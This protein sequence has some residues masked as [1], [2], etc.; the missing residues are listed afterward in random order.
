MNVAAPCQ[1]GSS[2]QSLAL[3]A[4]VDGLLS[5]TETVVET[6]RLPLAAVDGRVL[7]VDLVSCSAVPPFDNSAMDGYALRVGDLAGDGPWELPV[8]ARLT[9]GTARGGAPVP[10]GRAVRIF[11]GAPMP[12]GF[13]AVV[14]QERCMRTAKGVVVQARPAL[15]QNVRSTGEDVACGV[16]IVAAGN[17]M[18]PER[19]ALSAAAGIAEVE[20]RRKLRIGVLSTGSELQQPGERL[21]AGQIY[22]SNRLMAIVSLRRHAW[23]DVLDFGSVKDSRVALSNRI[24]AALAACDVVI[25]S[26]GASG[27]EEDHLRAAMADLG[28]EMLVE[29][30]A[31]RPGKPVKVARLERKLLFGLPG[32]PFA[33]AVV[34]RSIAMP[35]IRKG[36]GEA[37]VAAKRFGIAGFDQEKRPDVCEF[38][39]V[40]IKGSDACG[41][42]CLEMLGRGSSASLFPLSSADGFAILPADCDR[43]AKGD[44]VV[45]DAIGTG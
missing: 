44:R 40:A 42:P 27:G 5:G 43:I 6:E 2:G 24:A 20:V 26:G 11:T 31:M 22:D 13:D 36:A 30:I 33:A 8:G 35:V 28:A 15:R 10:S 12:D 21:S 39:P 4:A 3:D 38:V 1:P 29:R 25:T 14:M 7:A 32:N 23:A 41:L 34:L 18:T 9:A 17:A 16:S 19:I 45:F 37:A